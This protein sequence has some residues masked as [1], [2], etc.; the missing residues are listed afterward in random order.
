[1]GR[2][3]CRVS[4]QCSGAGRRASGWRVALVGLGLLLGTAPAA[5]AQYAFPTDPNDD[6]LFSLD[7]PLGAIE[8]VAARGLRLGATGFTVGGFTT[9]EAEVEQ[10]ED[11]VIAIDSLNFLILW[12]PLDFA[13]AFA[14]F[15]IGDLFEYDTG[16][17]DV[18]SD[19][20]FVVERL[21]G[22]LSRSDALN[23]R[24]G[25]FQSPVGIWNLVPAEPFTWTATEPVLVETA[26]DEHQT[27]GA[28]YGSAFAGDRPLDYMLYGQ[29]VDAFDPE[30]DED[31]VDR[32]VGWRLRYGGLLGEW[33]AGA[34]FLASEKEGAWNFL[35]GV[36][37][38]WRRGAL[39]LQG[40]FAIVRGDIPGRNLW[41]V[42][43]QG[44]YH[45]GHHA[46]ILTG[47]HVV[48]RYEHFN[49]PGPDEDSNLFNVGFTFVRWPFL[50]VK[51]TYQF[52]TESSDEV[53]RGFAASIS[54]VF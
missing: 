21:H 6:P 32:S 2:N 45:L 29:F 35:G 7:T 54:V 43:A 15:E 47:L 22:D 14:E 37:G 16:S 17:G 48:G 51:A 1:M 40:E 9:F 39:E 26:F 46:E 10:K 23:L 8:Y 5:R 50:V 44:V 33:A 11:G 49:P 34:S 4:L 42:Y 25:K 27:G 31:P 20:V 53:V 28:F 52:A 30:S 41:G 12:E 38:F 18:E 13:R 24:I 36:D 19:P 3:A